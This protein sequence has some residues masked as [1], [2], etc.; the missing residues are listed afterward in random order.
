MDTDNERVDSCAVRF[1]IYY[2]I[3]QL[4]CTKS[5]QTNH[6]VTYTNQSNSIRQQYSKRTINKSINQSGG[7]V[8]LP[9]CLSVCLCVCP[10]SVL[11]QNGWMHPDAISGGKSA[12]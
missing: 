7:P 3:I 11:W 10:E 2:F 9:I 8:A 12:E 1:I 6:G 5:Y 4:K